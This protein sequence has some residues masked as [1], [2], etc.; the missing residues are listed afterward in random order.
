MAPQSWR[1]ERTR[2]RFQHGPIDL[3]LSFEG[4]DAECEAAA[5]QAWGAFDG[6]LEGLVAELP[7]LRRPDGAVPNSP[8]ARAMVQAVQP[9][10][11]QFITPMAAVAG[12]VSDHILAAAT[13]GLALERGFV[14]NGGDIALYL[15]PG[16]RFDAGI[17]GDISRP[18]MTAGFSLDHGMP[19]RGI[20]TSGWRGRSR[21]LGIADAV[22]ILAA[23]AAQADAA[24]T[25]VANAVNVEHDAIKR[26]PASE[27]DPDSDLGA[28]LVT[29]D[30]APLPADLRRRA[31][32][33]GAEAARRM[34]Q[35]GLIQGALILLQ[36]FHAA[37]GVCRR[38]LAA[39]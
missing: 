22:T 10:G 20:A 19:V 11:G 3:L 39:A 37:A 21:S 9:H 24:A 25:L 31:V 1:L 30:V 4:P 17:V 32:N 33:G 38:Q 34:L 29:L 28:R 23:S 18:A 7:R 35:S 2:W 6:L 5:A 36:D 13:R 14:N 15:S 16:R 12:A 26:M 8:V 27:L